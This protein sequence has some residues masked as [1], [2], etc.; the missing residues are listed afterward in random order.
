MHL[1]RAAC[2]TRRFVFAYGQLVLRLLGPGAQK[3]FLRGW[4]IGVGLDVRPS[5]SGPRCPYPPRD[6][7]GGS[8][9]RFVL[10]RVD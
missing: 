7:R 1:L 8:G 2:A 9:L 5:S 3:H 6:L 4:A 10:I